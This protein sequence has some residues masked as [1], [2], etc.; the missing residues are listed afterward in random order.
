M[1]DDPPAGERQGAALAVP[2][3]LADDRDLLRRSGG[4]HGEYRDGE[5]GEA[6]RVTA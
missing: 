5:G 1:E 4:R 6:R 2:D 3:D